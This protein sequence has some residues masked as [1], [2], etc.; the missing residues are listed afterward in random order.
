MMPLAVELTILYDNTVAVDRC[1]ADHGF[2]CLVRNAETL[3]IFDTGTKPDIFA[4]NIETLNAPVSQAKWIALSHP[5]YDHV[6]GLAVAL[7]RAPTAQVI[8]P[9]GFPNS[10]KKLVL[11]AGAPL[12]EMDAPGEIAPGVY[13]T[14]PL[15]GRIVEQAL[16]L[17]TPKGLVVLTGCS[18]PGIAEIVEFVAEQWGGPIHMV[19]G[20]FHLMAHPKYAIA[21]IIK[22]FREIGVEKVGPLHCTGSK[23]Q[24]MFAAEYGPDYV[25]GGVG[26][27]IRIE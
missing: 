24:E 19:I 1:I 10:V 18:H 20:G 23:A 9:A 13:A 7:E 6:G 22:R 8:M 11:D 17:S 15:G 12:I 26:R 4:H 27:V 21:D 16:V 14:G 3:G 25:A 2:A 5:H